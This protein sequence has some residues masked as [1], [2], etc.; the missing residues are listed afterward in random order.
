MTLQ[1][2]IYNGSTVECAEELERPFVY[3]VL[4]CRGYE[5]L[6]LNL[7]IQC[8]DALAY[9]V[10]GSSAELRE[11]EIRRSAGR[12]FAEGN[13]SGDSVNFLSI[14]IY[15]KDDCAIMARGSSM[16]DSY[17]LRALRPK[18]VKIPHGCEYGL[19]FT[20][21]GLQNAQ[22]GR[23]EAKRRR[24]HVGV[25]VD[26]EGN[27]YSVDGHAPVLIL[28]DW[29]VVDDTYGGVETGLLCDAFRKIGRGVQH[30]HLHE[31]ELRLADELM[32]MDHEGLTSVASYGETVYSDIIADRAAKMLETVQNS[33]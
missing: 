1:K 20:S 7:H 32:Y 33:K 14:R 15:G 2:I 21:L 12:L 17:T 26:R 16:Y 19:E 11:E 18:A 23:I 27:V 29:A 8:L 28:K 4:R 6:L 24:A 5:P 10:L 22:L 31:T 13:Y 3:Q 25:S 30:R 9:R